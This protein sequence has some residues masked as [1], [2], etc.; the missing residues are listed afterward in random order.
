MTV[1]R[2]RRER[3]IATLARPVGRFPPKRP[4]CVNVLADSLEQIMDRL[5]MDGFRKQ[6]PRI[7]FRAEHLIAAGYLAIHLPRTQPHNGFVQFDTHIAVS[8]RP[9]DCMHP[10]EVW[11]HEDVR[12]EFHRLIEREGFDL[13]TLTAGQNHAHFSRLR[14]RITQPG[15]PIMQLSG[16]FDALVRTLGMLTRVWR[17]GDFNPGGVTT[18][19]E[20]ALRFLQTP[21]E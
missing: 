2:F 7:P 6:R 4:L 19:L 14:I 3:N 17:K 11:V 10:S 12:A 20:Y 15:R 5:E 9:H 1:S 8:D 13:T 21:S 16:R 18:D